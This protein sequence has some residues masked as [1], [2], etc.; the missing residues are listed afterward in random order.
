MGGLEEASREKVRLDVVQIA[1]V[2]GFGLQ[3]G[4][5]NDYCYGS[6]LP[7]PGGELEGF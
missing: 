3:H 5:D 4:I 2:A 6:Y 7:L 1:S